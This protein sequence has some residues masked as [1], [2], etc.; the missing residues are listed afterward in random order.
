MI[1]VE[2]MSDW[3]DEYHQLA[4]ALLGLK[5]ELNYVDIYLSR[6]TFKPIRREVEKAEK[7]RLEIEIADTKLKMEKLEKRNEIGTAGGNWQ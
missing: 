2:K 3:R 4:D 5:A 7:K 6:K 1:T